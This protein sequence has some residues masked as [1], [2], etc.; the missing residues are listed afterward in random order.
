LGCGIERLPYNF[1]IVLKNL[2][3][4]AVILAVTQ[5][6]VL[7]TGQASNNDGNKSHSNQA[8]TS[9]SKAA[10]LNPTSVPEKVAGDQPQ[11]VPDNKSAAS[12]QGSVK[13]PDFGTVSK[14]DGLDY[15]SLGVGII[16]ALITGSGVIAAWRGLPEFKKQADAAKDA[17]TAAKASADAAL[18]NAQAVIN[19]ERAWITVTPHIGTLKFVP[20]REK[21]APIPDDLVDVIPIIHQFPAKL[22]NVG[23]TPARIEASAIRYV[24]TPIHPSRWDETPDYGELSESEQYAFPDEI[25]TLTGQL[26]PVATMTTS[27]IEDV[28]NKRE[29]LFAFGIIKYRDVYGNPHETRFGYLY[30][31]QIRHLI[32]KD[33]VIHTI[34]TGEAHFQLGGPPKYNGHT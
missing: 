23:K 10:L 18:L 13:I 25:M 5:T 1:Y 8:Q 16:L 6:P 26:S 21:N 29:F 31:T 11:S 20:L 30:E 19:A 24:R 22:V 33:R 12:S 2:A 9:N 27:Q 34:R 3:I 14:R 17:A 7:A 15:A 4:L 28:E 32:M